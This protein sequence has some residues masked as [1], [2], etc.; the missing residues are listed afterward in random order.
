[1]GEKRE[2]REVRELELV[3][4]RERERDL[5]GLTA[6]QPLTLP[7]QLSM[8]IC[9]LHLLLPHVQIPSLLYYLRVLTLILLYILIKHPN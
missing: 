1:M 3:G 9:H 2:P 7:S 5:E 8:H 4:E 6:K